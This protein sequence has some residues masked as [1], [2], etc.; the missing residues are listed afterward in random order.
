MLIDNDHAVSGLGDNI[1]LM[2]LGPGRAKGIIQRI[3]AWLSARIGSFVF[4]DAGFDTGG[5]FG[6]TGQGLRAG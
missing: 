4:S 3:D 6:E 1:G 2:D 5:D